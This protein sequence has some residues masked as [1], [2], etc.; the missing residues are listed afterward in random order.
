[1]SSKRMTAVGLVLVCA[2]VG[3]P[4]AHAQ[5][6]WYQQSS[7]LPVSL[8][9]VD[10]VDAQNGWICGSAGTI[11]H[12]TN[13]GAVWTQQSSGT[14]GSL[15][16]LSFVDASVGFAC[17]SPGI[18]RT[19]DGGNT[20]VNVYVPPPQNAVGWSDV[21]AFS[22]EVVWA[23]GTSSEPNYH[24]GA[25]V[26]V[27]QD[28]GNTWST[29]QI[30]C[31]SPNDCR[32][33][34]RAVFSFSAQEALISG[35]VYYGTHG[36]WWSVLWRTTDGGQ[37]FVA[38]EYPI[39]TGKIQFVNPSV[40]YRV[41]AYMVQDIQKTTDGGETWSTIQIGDAA[42]T[43][44]FADANTGWVAGY[45]GPYC[46]PVCGIAR[47]T[48]GGATWM[49][50]TSFTTDTYFGAIDFVNTSVG[51]VVGPNGLILHTVTGGESVVDVPPAE[52]MAA[53]RLL[54]SAPNPFAHSV[55]IDFFVPPGG[56]Y[57]LEIFDVAGRL[58]R[59]VQSGT[60][61]AEAQSATWDGVDAGGHRA[62]PGVYFLRLSSDGRSC[63]ERLLML[64]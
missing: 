4:A 6:G 17:G 49:G 12:T 13:G 59:T 58:V 52:P 47:T 42:A 15:S 29:H 51:T 41:D 62:A 14:T 63:G 54:R 3:V 24:W 57:S 35:V 18:L 44:S 2:L 5:T 45:Q 16:A 28:G 27:T 21:H 22:S 37:T 38:E 10:L 8:W 32:T 40:G 36:D 20:W 25:V 34:A 7:P 61:G 19:L 1:M 50:Q 11:L 46:I 39:G 26:A 23:I 48:N 56:R 53:P 31:G 9:D 60:A 30:Y 33:S 64:Q 55:G 43:L